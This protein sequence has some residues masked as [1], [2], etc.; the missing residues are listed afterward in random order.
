MWLPMLHMICWCTT[1]NRSSLQIVLKAGYPV[2]THMTPA[3]LKS[4]SSLLRLSLSRDF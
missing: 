2:Q 3:S 4:A 1:L